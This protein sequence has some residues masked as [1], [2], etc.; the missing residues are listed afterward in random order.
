MKHSLVVAI[1]IV[2]LATLFV[3]AWI[4][5]DG[6]LTGLA[7]AAD[8]EWSGDL[9]ITGDL[10]LPTAGKALV[11]PDGTRQSSAPPQ[12][13]RTIIVSPVG[14]PLQNGTSLLAKRA[15]ITDASAAKPYLL[16]LEPG[17]YDIGSESFTM[18][19][20][21]D[22][23]GSGVQTTIIMGGVGTGGV[24]IGSSN[25]EIRMLTVFNYGGGSSAAAIFNSTSSPRITS[26][27]AE[28]SGST[29]NTA[30]YN[31]NG[32]NPAMAHVNATASGGTS[33]FAIY[34]YMS[35]PIMSDINALA[36]N[37]TNTN[38]A[39]TNEASSAQLL[40]S[41]AKGQGGTEAIGIRN[42]NSSS[43]F[44][45]SVI[46]AGEGGSS[47]YG[48]KND[49]SSPMIREVVARGSSGSYSYGIY[50]SEG[51]PL[52]INVIASSS[53]STH[54]TGIQNSSASTFLVNVTAAS[55]G[56]TASNYGLHNPLGPATVTADRCSFRGSTRAVS[57]VSGLVLKMGGTKLAGT[58]DTA[59]GTWTCSNCYNENGAALNGSCQ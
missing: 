32:S 57:A 48:I 33:A 21:I 42:L 12:Y 9:E 6:N 3:P 7:I 27:N 39:I 22:T 23:E 34:S 13:A 40:Y 31:V 16:K 37:A 50:Q 41:S 18:A 14:T 2:G 38:C 58:L 15:A 11:F 10:K 8:I 44:L 46:A 30:I 5:M 29:T 54:C 47:S 52:L 20:Y 55:D 43:P 19:Q 51:A 53:G 45:F 1:V 56:G 35:S 59:V 49:S 25:A 28:A 36:Q 4:I 24:I 17:T 26:L